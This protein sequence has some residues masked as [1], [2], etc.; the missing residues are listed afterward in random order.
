MQHQPVHHAPR[1]LLGHLWAWAMLSV[2]VVWLSLGLAAYATGL[3]EADE[4]LEGQL[5]ATAVLLLQ[6]PVHPAPDAP[7]SPMGLTATMK[8]PVPTRYAPPLRAVQWEGRGVTSDPH[9]L[10]ARLAHLSAGYHTVSLGD[11]DGGRWRTLVVERHDATGH[12]HRVAVL[13]D[14]S[15]RAELALDIAIDVAAPAILL[16]PLVALGLRWAIGRGLRPLQT[17]SE[18]IAA[19]DLDAGDTLPAPQPFREL[20]HT[21][22]AINALTHRLQTQF[23]SERQFASDVAHE[24]RTPLTALVWQSRRARH[25]NDPAERAAA[26]QQLEHE[27]L[28][29]GH[30]LQQLLDLARAQ[31]GARTGHAQVDLVALAREAVIEHVPAAHL[32]GHDLALLVGD[33]ATMVTGDATLLRLALRNLVDN[34]LRHTPAGTQVQVAVHADQTGTVELAV[35]NTGAPASLRPRE[36]AASTEG[37]G[38]GL[39]LVDRIAAHHGARLVRGDAPPPYATRW[40]IVW[41]GGA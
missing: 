8:A 33:D 25:A 16:L 12:V 37:M 1:S 39:T 6:D 31:H 13:V 34:A 32:S 24:L 36:G 18:R 30:T 17:L 11:A 4:I 2:A 29:A 27:A 28:R 3:D 38:I 21:A 15:H 9:D 26:L 5:H 19:L 23:A 10:A 41:Q 20:S 7:R 22:S 40:A 35:C 14:R